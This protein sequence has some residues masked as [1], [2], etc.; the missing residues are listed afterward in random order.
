MSNEKGTP[1][2]GA[3]R[4]GRRSYGSGSLFTRTDTAG[5]VTW[6]GKW[7]V[8]AGEQVKRKIGPKRVEGSRDGLTR[9]QAEAE[10]RRLIAE[11]PARRASGERLLLAEVAP[12]YIAHLEQKAAR[13]PRS[14]PS[15]APSTCG[16]CQRSVTRPS[17]KFAARTSRTLCGA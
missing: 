16:S 1:V 2:A 9:A 10:L 14:S 6:Y 5:R 13:K 8:A 12:R 4:R 7:Y 11:T 3:H 17:T 15:V